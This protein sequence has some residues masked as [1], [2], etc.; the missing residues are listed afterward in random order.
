MDDFLA[1]ARRGD[2][3]TALKYIGSASLRKQQ[4]VADVHIA[5]LHGEEVFQ[6]QFKEPATGLLAQLA[7]QLSSRLGEASY[8]ERDG[9]ARSSMLHYVQSPG[10][11]WQID[12]NEIHPRENAKTYEDEITQIERLNAAMIGWADSVSAGKYATPAAATQAFEVLIKQATP[13]TK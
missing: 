4:A 12:A 5:I 7:K 3:P 9:S 8:L 1:A 2:R 10:G 6:T 13:R 11:I